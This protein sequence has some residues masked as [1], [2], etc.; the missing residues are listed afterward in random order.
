MATPSSRKQSDSSSMQLRR[1]NSG[2]INDVPTIAAS[3]PQMNI[4]D[5]CSVL[6]DVQT[7]MSGN[8]VVIAPTLI[9]YNNFNDSI[10]YV[11][12]PYYVDLRKQRYT[13][14]LCLCPDSGGAL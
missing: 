13:I 4:V 6:V 3:P 10:S 1:S 5:I 2:P 11:L 9:A 7:S 12:H 14:V 8:D